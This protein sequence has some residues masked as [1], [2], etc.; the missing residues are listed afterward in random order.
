MVIILE[1]VEVER[2]HFSLV[3]LDEQSSKFLLHTQI[4]KNILTMDLNVSNLSTNY[5]KCF[6]I[7]VEVFISFVN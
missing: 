2:D 5:A 3:P 1:E 6:S 4:E 7:Y